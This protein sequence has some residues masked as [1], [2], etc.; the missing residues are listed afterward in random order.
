MSAMKRVAIVVFIAFL[1]G[2]SLWNCKEKKVVIDPAIASSDEALFKAGQ[3]F[4]KKDPE[5]ALLYFRQ[6]ID[7][8]PKSFYAQRAKLAIADSYFQKKDEGSMILA[9]SEYREFIA[10]YPYSPSASYAQYQIGMCSFKNALNPGR[11]QTKTTQALAE[12]K[13]VV[14][15]YPQSEEAKLAQEKITECDGVSTFGYSLDAVGNRLAKHEVTIIGVSASTTYTYNNNDELLTE[16]SAYCH[17]DYTYNANGETT[18]K[19]QNGFV[20][21]YRWNYDGRLV[22][23]ITTTEDLAFGYDVDGIRISKVVNST[24]TKFLVDKNRDYAQVLEEREYTGAILVA[25]IRGD[26]LLSQE[27]PINQVSFHYYDGQLS[28]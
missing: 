18:S 26:D 24:F 10:L 13:K 12:F 11:D 2:L 4:I 22:G 25:Y 5:K 1:C 9:A 27:H 14:T 21:T 3:S 20:T 28:T 15:N 7:S 6:V 8:F 19:I 23:S 17:N 16:D